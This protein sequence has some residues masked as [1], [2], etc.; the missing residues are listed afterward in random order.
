MSRPP[1]RAE[2]DALVSLAKLL[3]QSLD[4]AKG[5]ADAFEQQLAATKAA[6]DVMAQEIER[7]GAELRALRAAVIALLQQGAPHLPPALQG[8]AAAALQS[9]APPPAE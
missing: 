6:R 5:R 4:A 2:F 7:Q 3:S 9:L 8:A 1:S